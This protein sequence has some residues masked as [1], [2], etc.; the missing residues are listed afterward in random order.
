MRL[1]GRDGPSLGPRHAPSA[2]SAS[3]EPAVPSLQR[4]THHHTGAPWNAIDRRGQCAGN[5]A[6]DAGHQRVVDLLV[7]HGVRSELLLGASERRAAGADASNAEYL[8]RRSG[9]GLG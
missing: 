1:I 2:R 4:V 7:E 5:Y 3:G 8:S 6:L 9:L